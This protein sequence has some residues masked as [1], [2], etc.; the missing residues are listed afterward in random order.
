MNRSAQSPSSSMGVEKGS[1]PHKGF[2]DNGVVRR[3]QIAEKDARRQ[4]AIPHHIQEK[5]SAVESHGMALTCA[6]PYLH[7]T[8]HGVKVTHRKRPQHLVKHLSQ[9]PLHKNATLRR[10]TRGIPSPWLGYVMSLA[11]LTPSV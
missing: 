11:H 2:A 8:R 10:A 5:A 1:R 3:S 6:S 7:R 4:G 9:S